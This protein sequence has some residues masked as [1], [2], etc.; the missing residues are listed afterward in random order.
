MAKKN[1]VGRSKKRFQREM[2]KIT[3]EEAKRAEKKARKKKVP[4][5]PKFV[6]PELPMREVA[7]TQ[8]IPEKIAP[9]PDMNS[10]PTNQMD[11]G[12]GNLN[13]VKSLLGTQVVSL[14]YEKTKKPK[15]LKNQKLMGISKIKPVKKTKKK[16][17]K[18]NKMDLA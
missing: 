5:K 18:V 13:L 4:T 8:D 1:N 10:V 11:T 14:S 15:D 9:V 3:E 17:L 12:E 7:T 6:T 2:Q 16:A